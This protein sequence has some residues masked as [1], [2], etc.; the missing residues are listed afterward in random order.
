MRLRILLFVP[1]FCLG[2][3]PPAL[4]EIETLFVVEFAHADVGFN[5]PPSVM[6]ERN[7][8]RTL[9]ALDLADTYPEYRWVIETGYQLETFL[10]RASPAEEARLA[11]LL[12]E[13]RFE[14]GANFTNMRTGYVGEEQHHRLVYP[15]LAHGHRLGTEAATVFLDDVPGFTLATPR[16]LASAGIPY[17]VLGPND[18]FGGEPE[19]PLSDRAFWWGGRDGSRVLTWRTHGSYAEGYVEW[20]MLNLA[21]MEH[22]V[23]RRIAEFE[24]AGYPYDAVLVCRAFDDHMP[25]WSMVKLARDWNAVHETPRVR[26]ATAREFFEHMEATYGDTFPTYSGDAAGQWEDVTTVTPVS[27]A[28][29]RQARSALPGL[30]ALRAHLDLVEALPYPHASLAEAW[31]H[32]LVFDE[33]S[34]GGMGWPGLNPVEAVRQENR[35]F[36]AIARRAHEI[37]EEVGDEALATFAPGRVPEGE[38][39][40]VVVNPLGTAFE[41]VIEVDCGASQPP[42]TRIV[43][44]SSG[45]DALFRWTRKDRS[46]LA[47]RA[48]MPARG[49]ARWRVTRDGPPL[50]APLWSQG[51]RLTAGDLELVLDPRT[52]TGR[53]LIDH[54]RRF[55]WIASA[56]GRGLGGI[57]RG[58]NLEV[59]FGITHP[60]DPRPVEIR[61]EEAGPLFRRAIVCD[62]D[63][64]FVREYRL[65]AD[66]TRVDLTLY[67]RR[68][69]LPFVPFEIH[70]HHYGVHFPGNLVPPTLLA[71]DGPDGLFRPGPESLPGASLAHFGHATGGILS[72]TAGRWMAVSSPDA[73]ILDLGEM[74]GAPLSELENDETTLTAKLIRHADEGMVLGGEV[75][76]IEAEPG[77]ADW[78]R[79]RFH[80]RFGDAAA[81]PPARET[82]RRDV[83]PA[84]ATWVEEG[85]G[86]AGLAPSGTFFGLEGVAQ[87]V[88]AKRA[89]IGR[90][91]VLRLRA[92]AA[93]GVARID[94]PFLVTK[95]DLCDLLERPIAPLVVEG[96]S[97]EVPLVARGVVTLRVEAGGA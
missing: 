4:A 39:G 74:H 51:D 44:P 94:L 41:G 89:E 85:R 31:K 28:W 37:V 73:P 88:A 1:L 11:D 62:R 32:T 81:R 46:A 16:L 3:S 63:L 36:V 93:G 42:E 20:G 90:A 50:E 87:V 12:A 71:I 30:E 2:H 53:E 45:E 38:R 9:L 83:A 14:Y 66:D 7:H 95:A 75:L 8:E 10:D 23:P 48:K 55:D 19:I 72:G 80:V 65:F 91:L 97:V 13:G 17:A 29:V 49:W 34:G 96:S 33:H 77:T 6:Q 82:F 52:G 61:V 22:K 58:E 69:A 24:A 68:S 64:D 92:G 40:I 15:A 79:F 35:E 67:L 76:E 78:M 26:I 57:E 21:T 43:D 18:T 59:F 25:N 70:S 86:D 27:T 84:M 47:F 60:A 56:D 5:A 54:A